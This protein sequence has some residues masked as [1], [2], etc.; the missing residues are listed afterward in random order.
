MDNAFN[1]GA[2]SYVYSLALQTDGKILVGGQFSTLGGQG[3]NYIGRL[4]PD[5]TLDTSF[6]PGAS[7]LVYSLALQADG[8]ILV[9]GNFTALGGQNRTNIGRLNADG[10]LDTSFNPGANSTVY[11]L[12]VQADGKILVGGTATTL[13]G[14]SRNYIGR[15]NADGTLDTNFNPGANNYVYSLAVQADGAILVGGSYTMLGGQSRSRIG[16]FSADGTLDTSFNPGANNPVYSLALQTDGKILVG[17]AF[18]TLGGQTRSYVGRLN[19]T[20]PATQNLTFDGSTLTWARGG[21]GPEVWRTSFEYSPGGNSWTNLTGIRIPGGWQLTGL[22]LPTNVA[23]RA[24]GYAVGGEYNGS[25]WFVETGTGSPAIYTQPTNMTNNAG[26]TTAFSV[27]AIGAGPLTYQWLKDGA[28]MTD[29]GN[30]SGAATASLKLSNVL[31]ANAGGY[32]VVVSNILGSVTSVVA[33]LTVIDPL[34]NVQPIS[35]TNNA[36]NTRAFSVSAFGTMPLSYQWLKNGAGL[37]DGGNISGA[38]TASLTLNNVL[39]ADA[40]GYS[41]VVSN[42][43]GSVT[44]AVATLT[45]IDPAINTQPASQAKNPG[46][47][48]TLSVAA[49]GT[50]PLSYEWRKDGQTLGAGM[51]S[52]LVLTNLQGSDAGSYDVV[53]SNVWGSVTSTVAFLSVN[54]ALPDSFNP[55]TDG[56]VWSMALQA[57]GKILVGG[58][59]STLGGQS[60]N[61]IGRL[62]ADGTLDTSFNPGAGGSSPSVYSLA[63]QPDGKILVGGNFTTLGG[64]ISSRIGRVNPDGT[65]DTSFN[66]G[67]GGS[68]PSV[69]CLAV[70]ADGKIIVGGSFTTLGG[71]NRN[72]VGR[73]NAD[74]TLDTSF[75]PGASSYVNSMAVQTD[76]KILVGGGFTTL[77]GQARS[78]IG[79]LNADGTLDAS[80]NPGASFD[81]YSLALQADGKILVGG[82]FYTLGGQARN[83]IGR[84]NADGTL[85]TSFNP[86]ADNYVAS[87]ALQADGKILVGGGFSMLGGQTRNRIG[88]LNADGTLDASF[89][90]GA[91]S[92]VYSLAL[93]A[94]GKI[95]VGGYFTTLGGQSRSHIGRLN[96]TAPAT[97]NLTFDGSTLTWTRESTSPEVWRTTFEY[98][99]DGNSLTNLG[100]GSRIPGGWQLSGLALPTNTTFRARGYTVGGEYN[101]SSWFIETGI[102]S[103]V[104]ATQPQS[105]DVMVGTNATLS[106]TA[107]GTAPLNYQWYQNGALILNATNT[108]YSLQP[109][110]LGDAGNYFVVVANSYGSVTSAVAALTAEIPAVPDL[111][112]PG[113]GSNVYSLALQA[114]GKILVGGNFTTLAGQSCT[115]IGRLNADGT[116]DTSFNPAA[117]GYVYCQALQA[118]GKIVVGGQF[119]TLGGQVRRFIGRLNGDG[120]LDMSFNPGANGGPAYCLA[121]QADGKILVGGYFTTLGG[122]SRSYIGRLNADGTLDTSFNPGASGSVLSLAMQADGRI[123]V[124]GYLTSL[125]GQGRAN[126]GRLNADGTLDMSFNP[127]VG[128]PSSRSVYSLAAQAD[129]KILVGGYFTTLAGLSRTNI[130]RLNVDGTLD[131]SF[132]SGANNSVYS[133]ALQADGKILVGGYFTML[134]GQS[135]TNI[136]RLNQDGALDTTF[137]LGAGGVANSVVLSLALQADG[138]TVVGGNFTTL[139][140]QSRTNIGRLNNTIPATQ[141]LTFNGSTLTWTRGGTSPEVWRTTFEYSSDGSWWTALGG[142]I[143]MTGGWQL[144]G[145]ALPTN[146]TF[147]A[148]GYTVGGQDNGSSWFVETTIGTPA[149]YAIY[150]QPTSRTNNAGTIAAFSVS[151]GPGSLNYQWLKNGA[152]LGDG[153]NVFGS[154]TATLTLSNVFGADAGDYSV[155]IS[156]AVGSATSTVA[157]LTVIDPLI[158]VQPAS[159][160]KNPGDS[161]TFSVTAAG[162]FPLSYQWR[163]DGLAQAGA[164]QSSLALTNLQGSDAGSYDVVVSNAWG[165]VTSAAALLSVNLASPGSL[166]PGASSTVYS[167]A[168]QADGKILVGGAFTMLGGRPAI[169]SAD[170]T[171][172]GRWTRA[173]I[174]GTSSYVHCLAVQADGKILVGGNFTTLGGQNCT[175]IGRLN[176]D[177]TLD[178]SFNPGSSSWV[179]SLA[180]QADGKILVGGNF[181]TLGGQSRTYIGRLNADGTLDTSFN[182]GAEPANA[183]CIRWRCRRTGRFWW[184]AASQRWAGRAAI[185][186]AGSM[187]TGR[188]TPA[189]IRGRTVGCIPWRCRRTGRF[190]WAAALPRWGGRAAITWAGST[191]TARLDTTFNP[192]ADNTL[193]SAGGAGGWE[194]SGG[195]QLHHAG[196]AEPQLTSAGSTPTARWTPPSIRGR[197]LTCIPLAV[198]AD[199]KHSGG[200][201][202]HHAGRAE[203]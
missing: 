38:A 101:G 117:N 149:T 192:G 30:I 146:A 29:G 55:G 148:R 176:A 185:I 124:G 128:G 169:I 3:R 115:N 7:N 114:D 20:D 31:G 18:A 52:S 134:A 64:L 197:A 154:T 159:Q 166:N 33:T 22:A 167:M 122:Q 168:L 72:Y 125:G 109:F 86:G 178:T 50:P 11:S 147:R 202:L 43:A 195:W 102:G 179:Y 81:V 153:G 85:D 54:L 26:T 9:G 170:S 164:T 40:A 17:G 155:V 61:Y 45:V 145:L 177:G 14:Q 76:G 132:N 25:A 91:S 90:P 191:P 172:M 182:P 6:N 203:P 37:A 194:D 136:G 69:N 158:T 144:T 53:V 161:A 130:G 157:T 46:D 13:G 47:S 94:D 180:L 196:R 190:W 162:T 187:P 174:R 113:A 77:G 137:N 98:S 138:K 87:L 97:Q 84:L 60:R 57:D 188:W 104:I 80:F 116:L 100:V 70:Q 99:P 139:G 16:R 92:Y 165:S 181:T 8:K 65:L 175:N 93:Q 108:T 59:F 111:F 56:S 19:N 96:N 183:R 193:Y 48:V 160:A 95:V 119:S 49:G 63:V 4:N 121:L 135:R 123:V 198:Q 32:S 106:V 107:A 189:S 28:G 110:A 12:V 151:A 131:S 105:Q 24:R 140:G 62:N 88:R 75:N 152:S 201:R 42:A 118:D 21:S 82:S 74:G 173:S 199:G 5:G 129:G 200:G 39:H 78:R 10:T 51:Q 67:A 36:G 2:N 127:G 156:N 120:T 66:T 58:S 186:S 15:L 44:S 79:R 1:P 141:S 143:R 89:N 133:L 68:S 73:L 150:I 27:T 142:G 34:I 41:V 35:G 112:N 83:R 71:Q 184:G 163:K 23:F 103:P 171:P 126:I